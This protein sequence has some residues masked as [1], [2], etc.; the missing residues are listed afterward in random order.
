M[1]LLL[2]LLLFSLRISSQTIPNLHLQSYNERSLN[3]FR[4]SI[5]TNIDVNK[6]NN[7]F[8]DKSEDNLNEFQPGNLFKYNIRTRYKINKVLKVYCGTQIQSTNLFYV[9]VVKKF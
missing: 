2:I 5:K 1:R 7:L 4:L 9:G 8:E 6:A 3:K